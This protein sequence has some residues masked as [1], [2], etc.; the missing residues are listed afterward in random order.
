[1]QLQTRTAVV[2]AALVNL[3]TFESSRMVHLNTLRG[4]FTCFFVIQ[5]YFASK[6][7]GHT[8]GVVLHHELFQFH[9]KRQILQQNTVFLVQQRNI[10]A[11]PLR[12]KKIT[13]VAWV[14]HA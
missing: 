6:H 1:M 13:A 14:I 8:S 3:N 10:Y 4:S 12:H 11:L 7:L 9:H 5:H 2:K